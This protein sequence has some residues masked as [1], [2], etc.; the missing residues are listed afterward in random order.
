VCIYIYISFPI[1]YHVVAEESP[2]ERKSF[3]KVVIY[4]ICLGF[5]AEF[6]L[7]FKCKYS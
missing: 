5:T 4:N 1:L 3:F 7:L 6:M 2:S